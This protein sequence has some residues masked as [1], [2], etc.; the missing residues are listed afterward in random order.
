[1]LHKTLALS[2]LSF[3]FLVMPC[4]TFSQAAVNA[5]PPPAGGYFPLIPAGQFNYFPSDSQA[6]S[7]VH[8]S[9][10]EPRAEN[11]S[12]NHTIAPDTITQAGY[13]GMKFHARVFGRIT[14]HFTGTTDEIIQWAAAKWSL[15]DDIIRAE[16]VQESNWYQNKKDKNGKPKS[17]QGYGDFG[18]CKEGTPRYGKAGPSSFGILQ[19]KWCAMKDAKA[20]G[21][22]G[23][24]WTE[25]STA[26]A[27][28][29]YAAVLRGCY[30]GWDI[31]LG[32]DYKAGDLWGCVG[33]WYS[34]GWHTPS[35]EDYISKV[36]AIYEKKPWLTWPDQSNLLSERQSSPR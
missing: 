3:T 24:P 21:Y 34:G 17:G 29:E 18:S 7:L 32:K 31:W 11:Y 10:W 15:P 28:D 5:S 19:D 4:Q 1:M 25:D 27:I 20:A 8:R 22:D 13:S 2:L 9:T 14:G 12:A 33:R 16:A 6:A 35:A 23:W 26:Y 36:K 30:E